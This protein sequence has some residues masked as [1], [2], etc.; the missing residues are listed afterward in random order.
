[1]KVRVGCTK[2]DKELDFESTI[3]TLGDLILTVSSCNNLDCMDCSNCEEKVN[4]KP[5]ESQL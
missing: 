5:K 2:C 1:M 4:S 3:D